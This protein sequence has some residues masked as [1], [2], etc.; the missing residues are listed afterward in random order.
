MMHQEA[1]RLVFLT[2]FEVVD[3]MVGDEVGDIAHLLLIL[4]I[5]P[6]GGKGRVVILSLVVEDMEEAKSFRTARQMPFPYYSSLIASLLEHFREKSLGG[7]DAFRQLSLSVFPILARKQTKA[8][9][10]I[11]PLQAGSD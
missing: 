5:M 6:C 11:L 4:A 3:G 10:A 1:E 7:V 8:L 9:L 2:M